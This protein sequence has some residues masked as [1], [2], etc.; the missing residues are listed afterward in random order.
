MLQSAPNRLAVSRL[1]LLLVPVHE[2]RALHYLMT[3][4][5][6]EAVKLLLSQLQGHLLLSLQ[7][8]VHSCVHGPYLH[9]H[10]CSCLYV[11]TDATVTTYTHCC[12]D[13]HNIVTVTICPH[14][15]C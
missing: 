7:Q 9:W 6:L 1:C 11:K 10:S 4:A 5:T 12:C 8:Q 13:D 2:R 14:A 15:D 3:G